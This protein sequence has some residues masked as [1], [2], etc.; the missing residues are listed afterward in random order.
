MV[1]LGRRYH[2]GMNRHAINEL[3]KAEP[4]VPFVLYMSNGRRFEVRHPEDVILTPNLAVVYQP[5]VK[6]GNGALGH[7][8]YLHIANAEPLVEAE[9]QAQAAG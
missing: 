8:S 9:A 3:L 6:M 4:F 5:H 1:R 2:P 7:L